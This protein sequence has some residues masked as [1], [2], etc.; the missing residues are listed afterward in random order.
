MN[1][2][3]LTKLACGIIAHIVVYIKITTTIIIIM[4]GENVNFAMFQLTELFIYVSEHHFARR[5]SD[6]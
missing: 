2:S 5:R 6:K 4:L 3:F 1:V